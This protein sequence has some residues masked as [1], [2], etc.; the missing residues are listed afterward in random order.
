MKNHLLV[1]MPHPDDET[2]AC[3]GTIALHAKAGTPITYLCGTRGEMGRNMGKPPFA[4]RESLPEL[5]ER[6]LRAACEILGIRDLRLMGL[7]DKTTEFVDPEWLADQ[8]GQVIAEVDPSL[9][10]IYHPQYGVHPDHCAFGAATVR[11]VGR[12]PKAERPPIHCRAFGKNVGELG[13]ADVVVDVSSV[14]DVK[15]AAIAAHRSQSEG[16]MARL[17]QNPEQ[18]EQ[19]KKERAREH[20][21]TYRF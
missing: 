21:W 20:Y 3:G 14:I 2:F 5:R 11:A 19:A 16:M 8:V 17:E 1:V 12:L 9:I 10:L 7:R 6:E 4:T 18:R 15:W 13:E